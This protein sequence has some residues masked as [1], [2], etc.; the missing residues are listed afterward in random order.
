MSRGQL[1][2]V[3]NKKKY[4][5]LSLLLIVIGLCAMIYHGVR[6]DGFLNFD[7]EFTGG[8]AITLDMGAPFENDQV[9]A[10]ITEVTGQKDP[11]I[12]KVLGTNEV[13]IK[14]QSVDSETRTQLL[15]VF[16]EVFGL[17]EDQILSMADTSATI[18]SEMQKTS[19]VAVATACLVMLV[20]IS[21]RFNDFRMGL[22][23]VLALV[24]DVLIMLTFYALLWI[25][26]DTAFIAAVL[27]VVGYSINATIVIF[28]RI[29]ENKTLLPDL[30][31]EER[32]DISVSQTM[33]RSVYTSL[34]TFF[35]IGA[36]YVFGVQSVRE[37][38]LPIMVGIISGV[39]SSVFLSSSV[40]YFLL[41]HL[42]ENTYEYPHEAE[43]GTYYEDPYAK[44]K[45]R[46]FR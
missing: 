8:T 31:V 35:T 46:D 21:I 27:T 18:S 41:Q 36:L 4:F 39:Y 37:F 34:T 3:K 15:Q 14:I 10:V 30:E 33:R 6:G 29:R 25:P 23:A 43:E 11:Q 26:V 22:S 40:W 1:H 2:I 32:I 20:Y 13:S 19:F 44:K 16:Q 17:T 28:D 7:I 9:A 5:G 45:H 42:K 12:Q 38:A 24:H